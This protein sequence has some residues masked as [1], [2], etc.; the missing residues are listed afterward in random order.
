MKKLMLEVD[1]LRVESFAID[2]ESL[3]R[4]TVEGNSLPTKPLCSRYCAPTVGCAD[5]ATCTVDVC[6]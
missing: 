3:E 1:N 4:G 2:A 6:C 5:T